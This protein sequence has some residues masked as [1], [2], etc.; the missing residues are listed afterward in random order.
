MI[1]KG[2]R[3]LNIALLLIMLLLMTN[4]GG[5]QPPPPPPPEVTY[6]AM[7]PEQVTLTTELP[8]RTSAYLIAE[9]R[10][11]VNGII[12]KRPF[13]EGSYVKEGDILYQ[14]DPAPYKAAYENAKAALAKAM[15]NLPSVRARAARYEELVKVK[16]ISQQEYDDA[17]A[18]LQQTEADIE[19][20][21]AAVESARINLG[22]TEIRAPISGKVGKSN[23]TVGALATAH[24]TTPL[25]TIQQIDPIYVDATQSSVSWLELKK[26]IEAGRLKVDLSGQSKVRLLLEDGTPYPLVGV[27]KFSDV[28]VDPTTGSFI[29][30]MVFPNPKHILLPGMYVRAVIQEGVLEE[31]ILIPQQAVSRDTKGNPFTLIVNKENKVELRPLVVERTIGDKWLVLSGVSVGDKVIMEGLQRVRPGTSVKAIPYKEGEGKNKAPET[32]TK[33]SDSHKEKQ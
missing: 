14:I 30:R 4:C 27:L 28:T 22:Y 17:V 25:T 24:Q 32:Q 26:R 31:A 8:A 11:Q 3:Y 2:D 23:I 1:K 6:V 5:K 12:V 29:L 15:A 16:A 7:K 20:W 9:I 21:K 10:P 18:A 33:P 13:E 19:Y